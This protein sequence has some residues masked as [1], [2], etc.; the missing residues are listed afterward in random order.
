MDPQGANL[1]EGVEGQGLVDQGKLLE[2]LRG[3]VGLGEEEIRPAPGS[4]KASSFEADL[5]LSRPLPPPSPQIL[6]TTRHG[7]GGDL[8]PEEGVGNHLEAPKFL[9]LGVHVLEA[10][11]VF[12][13]GGED[14]EASGDPLCPVLVQGPRQGSQVADL[15]GA[16]QAGHHVQDLRGGDGKGHRP[17][18]E[19]GMPEGQKT[20][21][22]VHR[23]DGA[24]AP[25]GHV[26]PGQ[27]HPHGGT[28]LEGLAG[29]TRWSR[30]GGAS[31]HPGTAQKG[32]QFGG[33]SVT[34]SLNQQG[35][36]Q[37]RKVSRGGPIA[38]VPRNRGG[39]V[40]RG[41]PG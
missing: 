5:Y 16:F 22:P 1:L 26:P 10:Q 28:G 2:H 39:P 21:V 12:R 25:H 33:A 11:G 40:P 35:C 38:L 15:E 36:R 6:Q 14:A 31:G 8:S 20:P 32:S 29:K 18:V 13:G 23:R 4:G 7:Q 3:Q 19:E 30:P 37:L 24:D 9:P 34:Q 27:K 17:S 41:R